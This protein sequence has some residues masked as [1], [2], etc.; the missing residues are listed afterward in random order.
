MSQ[1]DLEG[2]MDCSITT[3]AVKA[4]AVALAFALSPLPGTIAVALAQTCA[5]VSLPS[6]SLN[7]SQGSNFSQTIPSGQTLTVY[8]LQQQNA[9][10][11]LGGLPHPF[12]IL[13]DGSWATQ[14]TYRLTNLANNAQTV[15]YGPASATNVTHYTQV[16]VGSLPNVMNKITIE[17]KCL[18]TNTTCVM[19]TFTV[20]KYVNPVHGNI[21]VAP[22]CCTSS[23]PP[24][25]PTGGPNGLMQLQMTGNVSGGNGFLKVERLNGS[26]PP[27]QVGALVP[28]SNGG[29]T[30]CYPKG[31]YNISAATY[32][33][34]LVDTYGIPASPPATITPN[35]FTNC[36]TCCVPKPT[37][38]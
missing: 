31:A 11:E 38:K 4:F 7:L 30:P 5:C 10:L 24:P 20:N 25:H 18:Q 1:K 2:A 13:N 29:A 35:Q 34:T 22:K 28:F 21:S 8:P 27:T 37:P 19:A 3:K 12:N 17:A 36:V 33:T 16:P 15:L 14:I 6:A 32:R 23:P 9:T 26:N